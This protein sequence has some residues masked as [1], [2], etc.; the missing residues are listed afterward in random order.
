M[1]D[2]T[3]PGDPN[4]PAAPSGTQHKQMQVKIELDPETAQGMYTNM[5]LVNHNEAEFTLDF[6]YVQPQ[7]PKGKVRARLISSPKHVKRLL[8]ALQDSVAGFER[9]HGTIDISGGGPRFS[10]QGPLN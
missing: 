1:S 10:P 6:I 8:L 9:K 2:P 5:A 4:A 7:E 3:S